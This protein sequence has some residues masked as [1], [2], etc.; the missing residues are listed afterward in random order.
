MLV[1]GQVECAAGA[2]APRALTAVHTR[3]GV[4][5]SCTLEPDGYF[6]VR[7]APGPYRWE[8][9]TGGALI[10][11]ESVTMGASEPGTTA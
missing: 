10:V 5:S 1:Q 3:T 11:I 6:E 8:L 9:A 2:E 4:A 7:L